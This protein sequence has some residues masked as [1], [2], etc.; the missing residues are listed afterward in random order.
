M[1]R[2]VADILEATGG[3]LA[4]GA[5][6]VRCTSF[7]TD[8]RTVEPGGCFFALRG[9]ALDGHAY[10]A[11]AAAR[12]AAALVTD[13]EVAVSGVAVVQVADTWR[14]LYDLAGHV[15]DR[16][17]PL[18]VGVTGSNGKTSTKEM[19]AAVLG[20]RHQVLKSEGNLNSETGVPLTLLRLEPSDTAAVLERGMQGPGEIARLAALARPRDGIAT[21]IGTV[22][23]EYFSDQA[24]LARAKAELVQ[25][26]PA[27]G[28]AVLNAADAW[29]ELLRG[30]G[31]APGASVG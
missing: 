10:C 27:D 11:G 31:R 7:H 19:A 30:P 14:A 1:D 13:R 12:G 29:F 22:H 25:A 8:S 15:L 18:V 21:I 6:D 3:R 16:V 26:L 17:A 2:A 9:S 4:A 20:V 24:A 28:L 5:A 23:L